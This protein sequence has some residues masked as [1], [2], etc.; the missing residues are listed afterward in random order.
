[1]LNP[2]PIGHYIEFS[3]RT[4]FTF[5]APKAPTTTKT[6]NG[7]ILLTVIR[8]AGNR[9]PAPRSKGALSYCHLTST[10]FH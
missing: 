2:A 5:T 8:Q 9:K 10:I 3:R 4:V 6:S 1:M 7:K